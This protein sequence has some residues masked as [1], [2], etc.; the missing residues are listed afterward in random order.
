MLGKNQLIVQKDLVLSPQ[1]QDVNWTYIRRSEDVFWM[2]YVRSIYA[3]C[4]RVYNAYDDLEKHRTEDI[5][6]NSQRQTQEREYCTTNCHHQNRL[7]NSYYK[8]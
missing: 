7:R 3:L 5:Q 2:S 1:T 6:S 8:S 4:P